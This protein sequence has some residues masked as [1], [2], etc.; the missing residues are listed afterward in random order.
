MP[1]PRLAPERIFIMPRPLQQ[2][3]PWKSSR[4]PRR[5]SPRAGGGFSL[6]ELLIVISIIALLVGILLPALGAARSAAQAATCLA[7]VRQVGAGAA[8][9]STD[10]KRFIFPS[11]MMYGGQPYWQVLSDQDYIDRDLAVHRCPR[12]DSSEWL[13][14]NGN[15]RF[16][17]TSYGINA[18]MA[19]NHDPYGDPP[20]AH[21]GDNNIAG[22]F[23][24][25]WEDVRKPS[26]TIF[27]GELAA[28]KDSDHFMPMYWGAS[29]AIHPNAASPMF[30]MARMNEVDSANG[31]IPR[32]IS[33]DRHSNGSNDAFIDGHGSHHAFFDT[34]DDTIAGQADRDANS[35][36]DWYDPRYPSP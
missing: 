27:A 31:N 18:Y 1:A 21:G 9:F 14:A 8:A 32:S 5:R 16:R 24:I 6:I 13:D 29:A 20:L 26:R 19:P 25:R 11:S 35:K 34:W 3:R 28:Y 10:N 22:E 4:Q 36:R 7:N 15:G 33:R 17:V 23:G 12:D 2:P 30:P